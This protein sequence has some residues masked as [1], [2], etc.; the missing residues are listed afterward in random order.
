MIM[1]DVDIV[2]IVFSV[3]DNDKIDGNY[4]INNVGYN[5]CNH[6]RWL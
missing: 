2:V 5:N 6:R 3:D 4:D 1:I